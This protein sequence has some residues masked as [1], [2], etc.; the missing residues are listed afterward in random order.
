MDS[1]SATKIWTTGT[2]QN[3]DDQPMK[4]K[5]WKNGDLTNKGGKVELRSK[6]NVVNKG[7]DMT[8]FEITCVKGQLTYKNKAMTYPLDLKPE[9]TNVMKHLNEELKKEHNGV[10]ALDLKDPEVKTLADFGDTL[11]AHDT[12]TPWEFD[13]VVEDSKHQLAVGKVS[14]R[15]SPRT[16][17]G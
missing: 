13:V 14:P 9:C 7:A 12:K 2:D 1:S 6:R 10:I 4:V 15:T 5:P 3:L 11:I 8:P 16:V 17:R